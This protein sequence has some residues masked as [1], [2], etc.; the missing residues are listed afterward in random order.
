M[1]WLLLALT[2]LIFVLALRSGSPG[3]MAIGLLTGIV[4]CFVTVL[5]FVAKRIEAKAQ[6]EVYVP[7]AEELALLR[8][9]AE[10]QKSQHASRGGAAAF[11]EGSSN[12]R[13]DG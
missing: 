3:W 11:R 4:M 7:S 1:R 6:S 2:V 9:R 10:R 5:A 13:L 8:R 12:T